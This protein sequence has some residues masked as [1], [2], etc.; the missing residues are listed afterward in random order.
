MIKKI[1]GAAAAAAVATA[2][3]TGAA[4]A[5]EREFSWSFNIAGTSNYMFR[6]VSLSGDEPVVQ[7]GLDIGYGTF[8]AG[9]WASDLGDYA[10]GGEVD[11]YLGLTPKWGPV[12]FDFGAVLYT[13]TVDNDD[14]MYTDLKAAASMDLVKNLS[15]GVTLW[16]TPD[17]SNIGEGFAVEGTLAYVLPQVSVFT[18]T[19]SGLLGHQSFDNSYGAP[20]YLYWNAGLE[21]GVDKLSLDFRYWDT[22]APDG[23]VFS[24]GDADSK[25][26]FTAKV[27]LP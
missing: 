6:G 4:S 17:Q 15:G 12:T 20:D 10:E 23:A 8:Y 27:T 24:A 21:L 2:A 5:E 7:G 9:V 25:F 26:V 19:I 14:L 22:D 18:P 11:F 13:Y 3:F 16:Y 1:L